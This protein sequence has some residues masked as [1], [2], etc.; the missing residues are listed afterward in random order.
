M[1][2][3][4]IRK[5]IIRALSLWRP[6]TDTDKWELAV[7]WRD[8]RDTADG[9]VMGVLVSPQYENAKLFVNLDLLSAADCTPRGLEYTVVHELCH[10]P[11][12]MLVRLAEQNNSTDRVAD[13]SELA[14][15]KFAA[16]LWRAKYDCEPP[17]LL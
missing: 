17:P 15:K 6:I 7:L 14:T 4:Q 16:A 1:T 5:T 10:L 2:R 9:A 11:T 3:V 13:A 12:A 8:T